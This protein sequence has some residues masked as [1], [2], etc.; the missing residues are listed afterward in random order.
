[1]TG[2]RGKEASARIVLSGMWVFEAAARGYS[3][4]T[5]VVPVRRVL[6]RMGDQAARDAAFVLAV[7]SVWGLPPAPVRD[8]V[9]LWSGDEV[10]ARQVQVRDWVRLQRL[11]AQWW[12]S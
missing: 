10:L 12:L 1:M 4:D 5:A 6:D 3:R 11:E 7:E 2:H 9:G 8:R